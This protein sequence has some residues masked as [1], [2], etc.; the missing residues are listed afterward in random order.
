MSTTTQN[1][2]A[3]I[4]VD[5]AELTDLELQ[6]VAGA[7]GSGWVHTLGCCWCLPWYSSYTKCGA[8][9]KQGTCS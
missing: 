4:E 9:C 8:I 3:V 7:A 1:A 5:L 2:P 6:S